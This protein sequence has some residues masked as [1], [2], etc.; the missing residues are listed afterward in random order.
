MSDTGEGLGQ[1]SWEWEE[2]KVGWVQKQEELLGGAGAGSGGIQPVTW[3]DQ[4]MGM[5]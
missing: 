2:W 5:C 3:E 1:V 4:L